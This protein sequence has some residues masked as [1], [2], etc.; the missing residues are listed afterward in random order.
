MPAVISAKKFAGVYVLNVN[1]LELREYMKK[2]EE[3][4]L[5][6]KSVTP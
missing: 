6:K 3:T 2:V 4:K 5:A 1:H